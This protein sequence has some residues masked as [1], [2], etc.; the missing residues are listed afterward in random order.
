MRVTGRSWRTGDPALSTGSSR[1]NV[2]VA[3]DQVLEGAQL[4]QPDRSTCV[5]LLGGVSDLRPHPELP[6]VGE[7]RGGVH[8][9]ACRVHTELEGPGGGG[10]AGEDRLG[11]SAA[12]ASDVLDRLS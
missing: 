9:H 11:V 12:V 2:P 1:A 7:A 4:P 6:S 3:L 5:Q 8:V 10:V